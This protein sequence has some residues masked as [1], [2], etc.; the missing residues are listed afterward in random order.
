MWRSV[1]RGRIGLAALAAAASI[2][3]L[4]VLGP[5]PAG[6]QECYERYVGPPINEAGI[7]CPG[8]PRVWKSY[9]F[10]S[11][12]F[13]YYTETEDRIGYDEVRLGYRHQD[14]QIA[15]SILRCDE[16]GCEEEEW[17]GVPFPFGH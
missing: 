2:G 14:G 5:A 11:N 1:S 10:A 8:N 17:N 3:T 12:G 6:A 7:E 13:G 4:A 16:D 9:T 15:V